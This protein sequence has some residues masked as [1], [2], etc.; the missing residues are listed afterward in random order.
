MSN[1]ICLKEHLLSKY[2]EKYVFNKRELWEYIL[3][4]HIKLE[5]YSTCWLFSTFILKTHM[6]F[7]L[8]FKILDTV[9]MYT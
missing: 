1:N 6:N 7:Y 2:T 8:G 3:T 4:P 9:K 5:N